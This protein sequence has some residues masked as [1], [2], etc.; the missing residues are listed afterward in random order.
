MWLQLLQNS[1]PDP[2]TGV[3][4]TG[5]KSVFLPANQVTTVYIRAHVSSQAKGQDMYFS[6]DMF[7]PTPEDV[8]VYQAGVGVEDAIPYLQH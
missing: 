4:R 5:G 6:P 1:V 3:V 2:E 7:N 8:F